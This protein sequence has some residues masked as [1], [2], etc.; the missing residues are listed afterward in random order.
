MSARATG[1]C[2]LAE[3]SVQEVM[4]LGGVAHL[5]A[6]KGSLPFINFF[7][8]FRT[9]HE[10]RVQS[11]IAGLI[12]YGISAKRNNKCRADCIYYCTAA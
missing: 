6:L 3:S 10:K 1:C 8:G 4:D 2:M 11:W 5:A 12:G 7:D 9:S